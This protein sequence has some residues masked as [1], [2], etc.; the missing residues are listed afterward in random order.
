MQPFW[1]VCPCLFGVEGLVAEEL[2]AMQAEKVQ[3]QNGRVIFQGDAS[4]LARVNLGS[5]FS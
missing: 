4:L 3:A 5:R 2:R 1:M